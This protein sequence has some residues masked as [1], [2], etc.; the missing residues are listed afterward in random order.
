MAA[1]AQLLSRPDGRR[2]NEHREQ[3][4]RRRFRTGRGVERL[5]AAQS[6]RAAAAAA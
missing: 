1:G 5:K 4:S 6:S 3:A 2:R